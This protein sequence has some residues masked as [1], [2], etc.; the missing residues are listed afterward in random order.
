MAALQH[1]G[2]RCKNFSV[3]GAV[4]ILSHPNTV[5][6]RYCALDLSRSPLPSTEKLLLAQTKDEYARRGNFIRIFPSADSWE[7]YG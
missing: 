2:K 4:Q 7:L 1:E 6:Q 3:A 5:L